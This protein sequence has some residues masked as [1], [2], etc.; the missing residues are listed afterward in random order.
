[1]AGGQRI[2]TQLGALMFYDTDRAVG[3]MANSAGGS[4]SVMLQR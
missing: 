4:R 1:M 2:A 3:F